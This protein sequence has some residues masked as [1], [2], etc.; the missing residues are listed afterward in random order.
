MGHIFRL[1]LERH[2]TS[3]EMD[4]ADKK[5]YS[6]ISQTKA[7][8]E[9][10]KIEPTQTNGNDHNVDNQTQVGVEEN[11]SD[12]QGDH[13]HLHLGIPLTDLAREE[14]GSCTIDVGIVTI[15]MQPLRSHHPWYR[16]I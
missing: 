4:E 10:L 2:G 15:I 1:K 9:M 16:C 13:H 5:R 8:I 3:Q 12:R 7:E 6:V 11:E 14:R